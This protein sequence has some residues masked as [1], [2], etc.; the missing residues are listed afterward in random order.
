MAMVKELG[1]IPGNPENCIPN[2][3]P[4]NA[5]PGQVRVRKIGRP[6]LSL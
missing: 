6:T 3:E 2:Q 4:S 5:L 1:K